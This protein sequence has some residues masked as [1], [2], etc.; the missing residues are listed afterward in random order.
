MGSS[1]LQSRQFERRKFIEL[2]KDRL[3]NL[4]GSTATNNAFL[5]KIDNI[6]IVDFSDTGNACYGYF[7][8]P[9]NINKKNITVAELKTKPYSIFKSGFGEATALSHSGDWEEKFDEKLAE[10]GIFCHKP[11][12]STYKKPRYR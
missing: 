6:Y 2:N 8:L 11:N 7:E 5:L 3:K 1:A 4:V 9:F 12:D 10:L